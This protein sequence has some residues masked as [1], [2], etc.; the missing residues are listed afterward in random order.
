M[1][2]AFLAG[3]V[4][5]AAGKDAIHS[6]RA[7]AAWPA[8]QSL[9][10]RAGWMRPKG[11]Q[12]VSVE[13]LLA[14][15]PVGFGLPTPERVA[16][17]RALAIGDASD[18]VVNRREPVGDSGPPSLAD[19]ACVYRAPGSFTI[20]TRFCA[21]MVNSPRCQCVKIW[22]TS[23]QKCRFWASSAKRAPKSWV[24]LSCT[25]GL[26]RVHTSR[27]PKNYHRGITRDGADPQ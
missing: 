27:F 20:D 16:R 7:L 10:G 24:F 17:Q 8:A 13:S 2:S 12:P 26:P 11:H 15:A 23:D 25:L 21:P 19:L 9:L 14:T 18:V 5:R 1:Y 6:S 4:T 3:H 22:G